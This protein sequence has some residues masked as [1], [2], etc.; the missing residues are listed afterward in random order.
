MREEL[1]SSS[2]SP[3]RDMIVEKG[4]EVLLSCKSSI[5]V[6][7]CQWSWKDLYDDGKVDVKS[8]HS[9]G[10]DHHD[11]SVRFNN[12][13][14]DQQG[15]WSCAVR[16]KNDTHF[17]TI[18]EVRL[19]VLPSHLGWGLEVVQIKAG[20]M[21]LGGGERS[22]LRAWHEKGMTAGRRVRDGGWNLDSREKG[23]C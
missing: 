3:P 6:E 1:H 8:F 18:T 9:F 14:S 19:A 7:D 15:V 10:D 5:Q 11:C 20:D 17:V 12:I 2:T 4:S 22:D 21:R 16:S 23:G 13:L